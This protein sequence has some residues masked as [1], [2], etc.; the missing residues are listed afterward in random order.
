MRRFLPALLAIALLP[1]SAC[2]GVDASLL[3]TA[4]HN[5]EAAGGAELA[6]QW[7][8]DIPGRPPVVMTGTGVED[9]AKQHARIVAQLPPQAPRAGEFEVIADGFVMYMR[10]DLFADELGGKEW[11]KLDLGRAYD[12]LGIEVGTVGQVGQGTAQQLDALAHVSDGVSDEGREPI[13]GVE[14][15][16]YSATVDLGKLPG[17]NID[18]LAELSGGSEIPVDIWIDD[19]ERIRRFEWEQSLPAVEGMKMTMVAE[20]VRFGVPVNIDAPDEDDVLDAT[21]ITVRALQQRLN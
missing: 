9:A 1:L 11:M 2:G 17:K 8:Y 16:H 18:K 14:T 15:T 3:A 20:Y 10:S 4:V 7:T 5:T 13:R 12:S 19:Q 6:F 21:D